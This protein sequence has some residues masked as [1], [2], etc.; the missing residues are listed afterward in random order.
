ML[1][2]NVYEQMYPYKMNVRASFIV[3]CLNHSC[4]WL[5]EIAEKNSKYNSAWFILRTI[6]ALGLFCFFDCFLLDRSYKFING[7]DVLHSILHRNSARRPSL[8]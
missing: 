1:F 8:Y 5:T 6:Y 4:E 7:G 3:F 2:Q